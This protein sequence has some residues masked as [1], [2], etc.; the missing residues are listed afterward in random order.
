[1]KMVVVMKMVMVMRVMVKVMVGVMIVVGVG[2]GVFVLGGGV[3][4]GG[5]GLGGRLGGDGRLGIRRLRLRRRRPGGERLC[6]KC[7]S[8]HCCVR[9][10]GGTNGRRGGVGQWHGRIRRANRRVLGG[11]EGEW[12]E[13]RFDGGEGG[14]DDA[15][16]PTGGRRWVAKWCRSGQGLG[17]GGR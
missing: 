4:R 9:R 15:G 1:M 8:R 14:R 16:G 7:R 13:R 3:E 17:G 6:P 10:S 2:V 11:G 5:F 12:C